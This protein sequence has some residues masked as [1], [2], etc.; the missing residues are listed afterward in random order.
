MAL[1]RRCQ[2]A[3]ML[4]REKNKMSDDEYIK[5]RKFD[6]EGRKGKDI[7]SNAKDFLVI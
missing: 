4:K 7:L 2:S 6:I 3:K 1:M 5:K